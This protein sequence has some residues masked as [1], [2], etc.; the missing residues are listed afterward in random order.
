M[1]RTDGELVRRVRTGAREEFGELV[2]R[3][4]DSLYRYALGMVGG[5]D[6]AADIVQD[7]FVKAFSSLDRCQEPDRFG[8]WVFRILRN[9]CL[10]Y[11]KNRRR[12]DVPLEDDAEYDSGDDPGS[13]L[14]RAEIQRAVGAA[15]LEL[16][17]AQREAFLMKH[18]DDLSYDEMAELT[19]VS[20][21]ALKMRVK[22]ARETLQGVLTA[23]GSS[24]L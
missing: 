11:L 9:R 15:L 10:D 13:C 12:R 19:G 5:G 22:R 6:A 20:V 1:T 8:A 3:H 14:D 18:V 4:Q 17:H 2:H 16:P 7:S 21:S 23:G 24:Q